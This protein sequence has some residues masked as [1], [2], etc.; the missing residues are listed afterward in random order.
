MKL[1]FKDFERVISFTPGVAIE[2]VIENKGCFFKTVS[3]LS[4]QIDGEP[5]DAVLSIGNKPVEPSRY[6]DMILQFAPFSLNRKSLLTKLTNAIEKRAVSAELYVRAQ[7]ILAEIES[8]VQDAADDF[9]FEIDCSKIA[10]GPI[11]RSIG[12]EVSEDN[13]GTLE[14]IINYMEIV[15]ELD[16]DR[17]F[18]T[19]NMRTYFS[20]DELS[21]FINTA[22]LHDFK[23]LLLEST[24]G[25]LLKNTKRYTIDEDLCEF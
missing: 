17:L 19:V 1:A 24:S 16:K 9:P 20:D 25:K 5:G 10:I 21:S 15:R 8:L 4:T 23:V 12:I 3:G 13:K 14:K 6:A 22:C 7:S 18:I 11:L 2:L